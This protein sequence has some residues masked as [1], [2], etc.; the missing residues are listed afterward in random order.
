MNPHDPFQ[1]PQ[2][3]AQPFGGQPQPGAPSIQP[4]V[5]NEPLF[6][7]AP[8]F[9]QHTSQ[10][11]LPQPTRPEQVMQQQA[12]QQST[13]QYPPQPQTA[14]QSATHAQPQPA[15]IYTVPPKPSKLWMVI[16]I[17][18]MVIAAGLL[19]GFVWSMLQYID[20]RDNVDSKVT[21]AVAT[22]VKEQSDKDAA[23]FLEKEKQPNRLFVGPDDYGRLA[24][25]YPKTWSTYID[26]D[27]LKG[28]AYNAYLNP[29]VVP[30]VGV[31]DQQYALRVTIEEKDYD[32][33]IESYAPKVKKGELKS[34]SIKADDQNGTLLEGEFSKGVRGT[35]VIFKIRDK[36]VTLKTD[37]DVFRADFDALVKTITFN[38]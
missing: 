23:D 30:P 11:A 34:S 31:V 3:G 17:I 6:D 38:K 8:G 16:A 5:P 4:Q 12:P 9:Q 2:G 28:G 32:K 35:A 22:A 18:L 13:P 29:V 21:A 33:V 20:Q 15:S 25:N 24:F 26:K 19:G 27:A 14:P 1:Q 37:A 10:T 36:T 7:A